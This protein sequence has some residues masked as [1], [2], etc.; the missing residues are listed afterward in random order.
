MLPVIFVTIEADFW[1][2]LLMEMD[3]FELF[4]FLYF[5]LAI[6]SGHIAVEMSEFKGKLKEEITVPAL[7]IS[8]GI[9]GRTL[10]I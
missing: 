4:F 1:V 6:T 8:G 3:L 5:T 10:W 9:I 2:L 7:S